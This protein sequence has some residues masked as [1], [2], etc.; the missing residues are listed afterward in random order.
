LADALHAA[1]WLV[2][3]ALLIAA[4]WRVAGRLDRDAGVA[5]RAIHVVVLCW[6]TIVLS[7][8]ALSAWSSLGGDSLL[9]T[10]AIL[11][12]VA[13]VIVGAPPDDHAWRRFRIV[14]PH[15]VAWVVVGGIWISRIVTRGLLRFPSD[16][17]CLMYHIPL[18]DQWLRSGSLYAPDASHWSSP[19]NN[20]LLGLW[21]VAPFSGDFLIALNN[22]PSVLLLGLSAVELGAVLGLSRAYRHIFGLA[23]VSNSAV[24]GQMLDAKNDV[25]SA[26]LLLTFAIYG[27][28]F[29]RAG[30]RSD[31]ILGGVA[32]GLLS[33]I[34]FYSVGYA[35]AAWALAS[36]LVALTRGGRSAV[37]AAAAW[38]LGALAFG[39]FW[40][41]RNIALTGSP[42]Y[43][44]TL[45]ATGDLVG[46]LYPAF[47]KSSILGNGSPDLLPLA[48]SA[49]WRL[50]GP[51]NLAAIVLLPLTSVLL[52]VRALRGPQAGGRSVR[53]ALG[54]LALSSGMILGLTPLC[55]EDVPGSLNQLRLGFTPIRYGL[56]FLCLSLLVLFV[57]VEDVVRRLWKPLT[58]VLASLLASVV[59][60]QLA[61]MLAGEGVFQASV[62]DAVYIVSPRETAMLATVA[63]A[64][65]YGGAA[66]IRFAPRPGITLVAVASIFSFACA[67]ASLADGWHRNF[68]KF[69]DRYYMTDAFGHLARTDPG[70]RMICVLDYRSYPFFGSRREFRVVHPFHVGDCDRLAKRL[71][72]RRITHV[73]VRRDPSSAGPHYR[74][75]SEWVASRGDLFKPVQARSSLSLYEVDREALLNHARAMR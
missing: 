52:L 29:A 37:V 38:A 12:G 44:K 17:D 45:G 4:G 26:A 73:A 13:L 60:C 74:S 47:W 20:E 21:L 65:L 50:A 64:G 19:G 36:A 41:F 53:L 68:A 54:C 10:T 2:V 22:V 71:V 32:L 28:G 1:S 58:G 66:L 18:I 48:A 16:F 63:V 55:V 5:R 46:S 51:L 39:G 25:A 15:E 72:F 24:L 75:A 31:L 57:V 62:T 34:K 43:P 14:R 49:V 11:S 69:Y 42:V 23:A 67:V 7:A 56:G 33:G 9:A 70:G 27:L 40:Y 8:F 35:A 59:A 30:R 3:N 61:C 6:G